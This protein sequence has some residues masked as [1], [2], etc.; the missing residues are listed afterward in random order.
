MRPSIQ[1]SE[2]KSGLASGEEK[3]G[4]KL[5][6][7]S[8]WTRVVFK[9]AKS[10]IWAAFQSQLCTAESFISKGTQWKQSWIYKER[11]INQ[12]S[13]QLLPNVGAFS[14]TAGLS[15][16][17]K[18]VIFETQITNSLQ[19]SPNC[20]HYAGNRL[21]HSFGSLCYCALLWVQSSLPTL[22]KQ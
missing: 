19:N 12:I 9:S 18:A 3:E 21:E 7:L 22:L 2:T 6:Q 17:Q 16:Q 5:Y 10:D 11:G 4:K 20:S 14:I 8:S 1:T 13:L 15:M